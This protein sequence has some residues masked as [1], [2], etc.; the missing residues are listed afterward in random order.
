M[1]KHSKVRPQRD[2]SSR[3]RISTKSSAEKGKQ[4]KRK[5]SKMFVV[6]GQVRDENN[7]PLTQHMVRAYDQD[8]RKS[9][10]LGE[11]WTDHDGRYR[12]AYSSDR[13]CKAEKGRA[14]LVTIVFNADDDEL[15]R[16]SVLFNAPAEATID[17]V[18]AGELSTESEYERVVK[19]VTLLL[20]G[21]G[22]KGGDLT[23]GQ[24]T[25]EDIVFIAND[26]GLPAGSI[27]YLV[28]AVIAAGSFPVSTIASS[29]NEK[30]CAPDIPAEV[31]YGWFR[32]GLP[33]DLS[34]LWAQPEVV[35]V[36][37]LKTAVAEAIIPQISES[38]FDE[39]I[40]TIADLTIAQVLKP[41]AEGEPGSL[42]D[43]LSTMPDRLSSEKERIA[44]AVLRDCTLTDEG[45]GHRLKK[46]G[47]HNEEIAN[48]RITRK[49]GTLADNH[50]ALIKDLQ[51]KRPTGLETSLR[52]LA[53]LSPFDWM[54]LVDA[55]GPAPG[56]T[57][58]LEDYALELER[59][60]E[61][62][63]PTAVL[64]ARVQS[65][66]LELKG[67]SV[68]AA[69][70]FLH[71]YPTLELKQQN[72]IAYLNDHTDDLEEPERAH[73]AKGLQQIQRIQK[74][75][76]DWREA[77]VLLNKGF[78]S[79]LAIIRYGEDG[80][81]EAAGTELS[82]GR[83][84]EIYGNA[85][86]THDTTV[87][88]FVGTYVSLLPWTFSVFAVPPPPDQAVALANYPNLRQLFGNLDMCE[89]AHCQ[90]VLSPAA[91]LVDLLEFLDPK[92]DVNSGAGAVPLRPSALPAL[93]TRRPDIA[94]LEL[95]CL[96]TKTEVPYI[97]LVLEILENAI[98]LPIDIPS[99]Y[100]FDPN[101]DLN[102]E[103][104][105]VASDV[106]KKLRPILE[107]SAISVGER[108][109]ARKSER[110]LLIGTHTDWLVSD[111]ARHWVLRYFH[112]SF[113]VWK[114]GVFPIRID[115]NDVLGTIKKL[116]EGQLSDE[117]WVLPQNGS[118]R[119]KYLPLKE[120]P[121]VTP[122][123]NDNTW[124]VTY[125]RAIRV[126]WQPPED[127]GKSKISVVTIQGK[128]LA[129]IS[130]GP[131]I[132]RTLEAR[133]RAGQL[134]E[135][136][137]G[138]LPSG[139]QYDIVELEGGEWEI[140]TSAEVKVVYVPPKLQITSL[141][142]QSTDGRPDL[143]A[144]PE[145]RN[146][147][148]YD[149][150]AA[151]VYPWSLPFNLWLEE[152]RVFLERR[153]LARRQLMERSNP[154]ARLQGPSIVREVLGLS[155]VESGILTN[156]S[157]ESWNYWGLQE[158]GNR[159]IDQNDGRSVAAGS[160]FNV[161][162]TSVSFLLQQSGLSYRELRNVLQT[163]F[164]QTVTPALTLVGD[165]CNVS[166]MMLQGLSEAHLDSIHRL[167]RLW[168]KLGWSLFEVDLGIAAVTNG[169][170]VLTEATLEGLSHL[171]RLQEL[172][173]LPIGTIAQWWAP[174]TVSY[175]DFAT[176]KQPLIKSAYERKYLNPVIVNPPEPD[177]LLNAQKSELAYLS[178]GAAA[179]PLLSKAS[180][181]IAILGI[182]QSELAQLVAD[183]V[184]QG[185][186]DDSATL[187]LVNL[188]SVSRH[189]GLAKS[190]SLSIQDYLTVK[191]LFGIKPFENSEKTVK[192][193]EGVGFIKGS[194]FSIEEV[195]YLLGRPLSEQSTGIFGVAQASQ[196]LTD[197]RNALQSDQKEGL[198]FSEPPDEHLRKMLSRIG[199]Y[200][201]LI[202]EAI[203]V[204]SFSNQAIMPAAVTVPNQLNNQVRYR[205]DTRILTVSLRLTQANWD[206]LVAANAAEQA[207]VDTLTQFRD[208]VNTFLSALP[209]RIQRM[210]SFD[211]PTH[212]VPY[213]TA[214]KV[215]M[216]SDLVS[217]C[218][219]DRTKKTI[220]CVGW[221]TTEQKDQLKSAL[222][223]NDAQ[224]ADRLKT[225]SDQ[226]R[227]Q[228]ELNR[229]LFDLDDVKDFFGVD[230]TKESRIQDVLARILIKLYRNSVIERTG[231]ALDV[232][233][234]VMRRVLVVQL[235]HDEVLDV[236][237]DSAFVE[238]DSKVSIALSSFPAQFAALCKVQKAAL[239]SR[240]LNVRAAQFSWLPPVRGQQRTFSV[241]NVNTLPVKNEDQ[242]ASFTEW[243][244]L[245]RLF[246][247]RDRREIRA[248]LIS[249]VLTLAN[250]ANLTDQQSDENAQRLY[251]A[252][253]LDTSVEE[254]ARAVR[255]LN[256]QWP[257]D[258]TDPAQFRKLIHQVFRGEIA[259]AFK[260]EAVDVGAVIQR[261][262]LTWPIDYLDPTKLEW[263]CDLL[264]TVQR[265]GASATETFTLVE[266]RLAT[267]IIS[268]KPGK[269]E[270]FRARGL[271]RAK[272]DE[273]TWP[274]QL[275][276][277][278][279]VLRD[280]QRAALVA[281]LIVHPPH[282]AANGAQWKTAS[283][284]YDHYLID[285]EMSPCRV[286]TRILHAVSAVQL[287]V[288]RCLMNLEAP[289]VL[290]SAI[291]A[292]RWEWMKNYRVWEANR[293]V[294][295]Y[296]ENW[297][298]PELRDDKSELFK[299]L[300]GQLSQNELDNERATEILKGY[301]KGLEDI[302][303]LNIVGMYVEKLVTVDDISTGETH[304]HIVGRTQN[305]PSH[306]YYRMWIL[307]AHANYW[308]AWEKVPLDG[309]KHDHILPFVLRGELYIA[310]P[311]FT[312][313]PAVAD[314]QGESAPK[315]KLQMSWMRR[316]SRGWSER[317]TT[318]DSIQRLWVP[319]KDENGTFTFRVL[320][321]P[322]T[323]QKETRATIDCLTVAADQNEDTS[324]F[325]TRE[326]KPQLL[327][328][329]PGKYNQ[330]D[331]NNP[332]M[333]V[334]FSG[335]VKS[336]YKVSGN[337]VYRPIQGAIIKC[338]LQLTQEQ[339]IRDFDHEFYWR[340]Y[341][342][343]PSDAISNA[344]SLP[345]IM[346]VTT[347]TG[348]GG[349]FNCSLRLVARALYRDT[350]LASHPTFKVEVMTLPFVDPKNVKHDKAFDFQSVVGNSLYRTVIFGQDFEV[351]REGPLPD[352]PAER[353][354]TMER[355][356]QFVLFSDEDA[357]FQ[358]LASAL[359]YPPGNA[360]A[361]ASGYLATDGGGNKSLQL[362]ESNVSVWT[363][364]AQRY[365]L[366][367]NFPSAMFDGG[368]DNV[369]RQMLRYSVPDVIVYWDSESTYFIRNVSG[370]SDYQVL[371]DGHPRARSLRMQLTQG[372]L[373]KLF[374]LEEESWASQIPFATHQPSSVIDLPQSLTRPAIQ[375]EP[376]EAH[377]PYAGYNTELFFHVPFLMA[378]YLSRNQRYVEAQKWFHY[379][380]D[381][382]TNDP[383]TG[384]ARYWRYLPFRT[385]S[386]TLAIDVLLKRLSDPAAPSNDAEKRNV[387]T[388]ILRWLENP[389]RPH[390][391]ARL[392]PRAYEFAVVFKYLDN[393]IAW[394]D[395]LFRQYSTESINEA[396]QLYI[397]AAKLLGSR[398]ETVPR[399]KQP[400]PLTYRMASGKWDLFANTWAEVETNTQ[401]TVSAGW[402][403]GHARN[404][405]YPRT[406]YTLSSV[407]LLY[408][409][410]PIND[411]LFEY[412]DKLEDRL[413]NIR[414]CRN[415]D[416]IEQ[417]VP[418]F[419]PPIDPA[420]LVR[421]TAAGLDI[422]TV[423][424][425]A[426]VPLPYYRFNLL[427]Q[428]ASELCSEV[429]ALGSALLTALE[430]K[431]AE[432]LLLM[433]S[434]QEIE[435]LDL[436]KAVREQQIEEAKTNLEAL[437]Q[438]EK[439]ATARFSQYQRLLGKAN[440][441]MPDGDGA[442]IEQASAVRVATSGEGGN[443]GITQAEQDQITWN[444]LA[445]SNSLIASTHHILAGILH[446]IPD[447]SVGSIIAQSKYGGS[448]LGN[449]LGAGA[450]FFGALERIASY[451]ANTASTLGQYQ[452][453]QDEWVFQSRLALREIQQ[454][455]KQIV[456][457]QIRIDIST[458][459]LANHEKQMK[460]VQ[461]SDRFMREKYTNRELYGWMVQQLSGVYFKTYQLAYDVAKR[462]ERTL[463]NEL[464][465]QSSNYIQ[466]GYWDN[467]KKGLLAGEK[468]GHDLKRMEVAYLEQNKRE[469]EITKHVSL[470][471]LDPLALVM[472][473]ESGRCEFI[474]PEVMFDL[475]YPGHYMRRLKSVS[476]TIPCVA[477][478]YTTVPCTVTLLKSEIRHNTL[479]A[480][481]YGRDLRNDDPRFTD[482]FGAIQSV[483]TSSGQSDSGM[484]ETNLRDER[485]L[486]FEGAGAI[487][488]WCLELPT[489][490]KP[491]DYDSISDVVLHL[492]YTAREGGEGLKTA[493]VSG[494]QA[495]VNAIVTNENG[496]G[497]TRLFSLK[498]E[499]PTEWHRF[500]NTADKD[501]GDHEQVLTFG[502]ERFP[503]YLQDKF[504]ARKVKAKRLHI[505]AIPIGKEIGDFSI[506]L[507]PSD[508]TDDAMTEIALTT[509]EQYGVGSSGLK[510]YMADQSP[511][512]L[513]EWIL[514]MTEDGFDA[515]KDTEGKLV[516][517]D[518]LI[519]FELEIS[520]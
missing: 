395:Q 421:A 501:T 443:L 375:F 1:A 97:D 174:L 366:L 65:G 271:L 392:R 481:G 218:F 408:F 187:K 426:T 496:A 406:T 156:P 353:R 31:F 503:F 516:I 165:E 414:H 108:L 178:G 357:E 207:V 162:K 96:N 34:A 515:L 434:R 189:V 448:H 423:L 498:H 190:L 289:D 302:A 266:D 100:G 370:G 158:Q 436:I 137:I 270:A 222:P 402:S 453:R 384:S 333:R 201:E 192:F 185:E 46:E 483:V 475:D 484:F 337:K 219:L 105:S 517:R 295:L 9:Q 149:K 59:R 487:S 198:T 326:E 177:F 55:H 58:D 7:R 403:F 305:R 73:L 511:Q 391:V 265:L 52:Y 28:Q 311:E 32:K 467:L 360:T 140:S 203:S 256:L 276:P 430:K 8:L 442:D 452:R 54:E 128:T 300:E 447:F 214:A 213:T 10:K 505:I 460:N 385:H 399:E 212:R 316:T 471:Q 328:Q 135:P 136:L 205:Q 424:S 68:N 247:L 450:A 130:V 504:A 274:T 204:L 19:E 39:L 280:K 267:N 113:M 297:I 465:L 217:R 306:F 44:A 117:E 432:H 87:A 53:A 287:F 513:G 451:Q 224:V 197:L 21:Q 148:A 269:A 510:D 48:L 343:A 200:G 474:M 342:W 188:S 246:T 225:Q 512:K 457:A 427:A 307:S 405:G 285:V 206:T 329:I 23:I 497:L 478:P 237:H 29:H 91:Y 367:P 249:R 387:Q 482:L 152:V 240:V 230:R 179:L 94:D 490:F 49:L 99:P 262:G 248:D 461:E 281:Y 72:V 454:I 50:T 278:T 288:Q 325:S 518:L 114:N 416:G 20:S 107:R 127:R 208:E 362:P 109:T 232:N 330:I 168:R 5:A 257:A 506:H 245:V 412:W 355:I 283:D 33:T 488:T 394:G 420:L 433:R 509:S 83:A 238:S 160:W 166:L 74:L 210:Q 470:L 14:D 348:P 151:A 378:T 35:L 364:V 101:T 415:I 98:G 411:R 161:L 344:S 167:V 216:P 254:I 27:S 321:E 129:S 292:K 77:G 382:T 324:P 182:K 195:D 462:A 275:K 15:S 131:L 121:K 41:A 252:Q 134:A 125:T 351:E 111:G 520:A 133:L 37:T 239:V 318:T 71:Q 425:E 286:S 388:Q 226:Y 445:L 494:L 90:S 26:T 410:I 508:E 81:V 373:Q 277:I 279:N 180:R 477:G 164:V 67:D 369:G 383:T 169:A 115:S 78:D 146:P 334:G 110:Q 393:L 298:E 45:F 64:A 417:Q 317:Q 123:E 468:L 331:P 400:A 322:S 126:A 147:E 379:I 11:A 56:A 431:D 24:L 435:L 143:L 70:E 284:L 85:Q 356:A 211:L 368:V 145:N 359:W 301:L 17:H 464:G 463:R 4:S 365:R 159:A 340:G 363:G 173:G 231:S 43:L 36:N 480:N 42:G 155:Q 144:S 186:L 236:L 112:E 150:L 377:S 253:G 358:P 250:M 235:R 255:V 175:S 327:D 259:K 227:E 157:Q 422:S 223:Q 258:F 323:I 444:A 291:D 312:R 449:I 242:P 154:T 122:G 196:V 339:A 371:L 341:S 264:S 319:G 120:A 106:V 12:I 18:I 354:L 38:H 80:F 472:F 350:V 63:H 194:G 92:A 181:L 184:A 310:W 404:V 313:L 171:K 234:E 141:T 502:A 514:R 372:G 163:Q 93:L 132:L 446:G 397:L 193:V 456:A 57:G 209:S 228:E 22:I 183:L 332:W 82:P 84:A 493:A 243:Q 261:L 315:W 296:P 352:A 479:L 220:T 79:S 459:E 486:P 25:L 103:G 30:H 519:C 251:L 507:A 398:P 389:F 320:E 233:E 381:P 473:K 407:G 476:V 263:L 272:Y 437:E 441:E 75:T 268:G 221:L 172:L 413:F 153:G 309:V 139:H 485:Y 199:W 290:P 119:D 89:C 419:Q 346:T 95:T 303:R 458:K 202:E 336:S 500:L 469:Y 13:F 102:L 489:N 347:V 215:V 40:A 440:V 455:R 2:A 338:S 361:H 47:F 499:F 142:Y 116:K 491:F 409:C 124:I 86:L 314:D 16:S 241:L 396:T 3:V 293:K 62:Q 429:K 244:Q 335:V 439:L 191:T 88:T 428:K 349:E 294:F 260:V 6:K 376:D 418:L 60:V 304:V 61:E 492:R 118:K 345:N 176:D 401:W 374:Q 66:S 390:A 438:S 69:A 380:F 229:F 138:I 495:A 466:F 282:G 308:T 273:R 76:R 170:M 104:R 299:Q 386:Q 51:A